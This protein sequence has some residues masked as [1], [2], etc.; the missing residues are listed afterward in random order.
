MKKHVLLAICALFV[1]SCAN[2]KNSTD[3]S[4]Q[5][6][7]AE[8]S[9]APGYIQADLKILNIE[10]N[11]DQKI[12]SSEVLDILNYG[13]STDPVPKGTYLK[14]TIDKELYNNSSSKFKSNGTLT[15]ILSNQGSGM[16]MGGQEKS[17][18]WKL[19]TIN[20]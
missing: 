17:N 20:N 9:L 13:S 3:T 11:G 6:P 16:T 12:I 15:A 18:L 10:D 5:S 14:F 19:I 4:Q 2:K 8:L 7:Q 1:I